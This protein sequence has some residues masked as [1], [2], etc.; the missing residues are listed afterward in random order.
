[1]KRIIDW[2]IGLEKKSSE[3]YRK[4]AEHFTDEKLRDFLEHS[5]EDEAMH[6][7]I[8][9]SASE[10]IRKHPEVEPAI[11]LDD[12]VKD[13]IENDLSVISD[14]LRTKSLTEEELI[15][16]I[17]E[18]EFSEWNYIFLY[19]VNTLKRIQPEFKYSAAMIQHHIRHIEH[20]LNTI[21]YGR[22]K[23]AVIR[24]L[25]AVWE[26]K[27]LVVEDEPIV[28]DLLTAVLSAEGLVETAA[29]GEIGLHKIRQSYYR[30]IVCDVDMPVMTG[31]TLY[32]QASSEFP[33][34]RH[35]FLFLTG[36]MDNEIISFFKAQGL[37]Y[38]AK[39]ASVKAIKSAILETMH[40]I[41][42]A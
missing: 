41:P 27:I 22:Q 7:H 32:R 11:T 13:R 25:K 34:I 15:E 16:C 35:R 4:S 17:V 12:A 21:P 30:M 18:T 38:L 19:V 28:A 23:L 40:K 14:K 31:I 3:V 33:D 36:N 29:N 24:N 42:A 37:K 8:M 20:F 9:A 10:T 2:L 5:A 39:P 1:M 6:Y 26:E